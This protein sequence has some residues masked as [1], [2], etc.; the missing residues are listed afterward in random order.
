MFRSN[1][2]SQ[3][4]FTL[5]EILIAITILSFVTIGIVTIT[6]NSM[7][8]KDRTTQLNADNL[9]IET[10]M[11]R[12]EW[13]FSQIY[14]PLYYSTIM[15]FNQNLGTTNATQTGAAQGGGTTPNSQGGFNNSGGGGFAD[16]N[17]MNNNMNVNPALQAYKE[18]VSI[19]MQTNEHFMNISKEGMP[20]PRFYSPDKSTFEF[21]TSS[22]R[23]KLENTKQSHFAWVRYAL[24]EA[25]ER[26]A[27][28]IP[29][30]TTVSTIPQGLKTF[31]RYFTADDPYSD[32]RINLDSVESP[33]KGAVLLEN[34]ESLEF[35]F[36]NLQ[37]RRWESTLRAV[38]NGESIIHGVRVKLAWYDSA[39]IKR[40]TDRI[41][42]TN[43]PIAI[44][45]DQTATPGA[46]TAGGVQAGATATGVQSGAAAAGGFN[47]GA[48]GA[49]GFNGGF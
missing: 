8:T 24:G 16:P 27:D 30:T 10:A 2:K 20:I 33:V 13:D 29:E 4:G 46:T 15:N 18:S 23:R 28:S 41:F 26:P 44:P 48:F 45:T 25:V 12:F 11:S 21:F 9:A 37:S 39:G 14:S 38:Q 36:W 42:R 31:V 34:V 3:T 5:I 7:Q 35:Q 40:T 32:K 6:D 43:W 1:L 47:S 19:R 22:N 49:G 17:A